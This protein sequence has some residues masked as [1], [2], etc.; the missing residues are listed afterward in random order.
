MHHEMW[1]NLI[2]CK[3]VGVGL[4]FPKQHSDMANVVANEFILGKKRGSPKKWDT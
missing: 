4:R 2:N 3:G 1:T